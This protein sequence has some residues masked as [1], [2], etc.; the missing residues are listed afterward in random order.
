ML[1]SS[2]GGG[3]E[4]DDGVFGSFEE[5]NRSVGGLVVGVLIESGG[6]TSE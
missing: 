4:G 6:S 5:W 3:E 2:E 1:A